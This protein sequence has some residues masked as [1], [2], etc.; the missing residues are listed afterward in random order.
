MRQAH[1][2]DHDEA[3]GK[4]GLDPNVGVEG[5]GDEEM[6]DYFGL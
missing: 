4:S 1:S 3:T 2:A 6:A 5:D